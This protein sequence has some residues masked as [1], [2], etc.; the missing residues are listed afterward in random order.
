[1]I[2]QRLRAACEQLIH[3]NNCEMEGIDCGMPVPKQWLSAFDELEAALTE[4]DI[5]TCHTC[6]RQD[7]PHP[8][9]RKQRLEEGCSEWDDEE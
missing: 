6:K 5:G 3:L 9:R 4:A 2:S 7:C 1:M 8:K